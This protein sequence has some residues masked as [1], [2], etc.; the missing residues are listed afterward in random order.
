MISTVISD[1]GS[2]LIAATNIQN[3]F[4]IDCTFFHGF[5]STEKLVACTGLHVKSPT[6]CIVLIKV[7]HHLADRLRH[8]CPCRFQMTISSHHTS[9]VVSQ[10]STTAA[11]TARLTYHPWLGP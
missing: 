4:S 9:T 3:H 8:C 2:E 7:I 1:D 11:A 10:R 6:H 5:D